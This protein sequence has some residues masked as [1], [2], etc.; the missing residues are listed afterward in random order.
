MIWAVKT[1]KQKKYER[2]YGL[3]ID[4]S[5]LEG[6]EP[7]YIVLFNH[8]GDDD[9]VIVGM[10]L[11]PHLANFMVSRWVSHKFPTGPLSTLA[12]AIHKSRFIPDTD[13]VLCAK[14]VLRN[15]KGIVAIAPAA[16]FSID[17]TTHYFDY[18]IAKLVRLFKVP[19]FAVKMSGLFLFHNGYREQ[20]QG[21][22]LKS[23]VIP[24]F[25]GDEL[26]DMS[27]EDIYKR[28]FEACDFND[29][30]Y[31][32][33]QQALITAKNHDLAE[34]MEYLTYRCLRCGK[35]FTMRSRG[36]RLYCTACGNT[37]K[38]NDRY[39]LEPAESGSVCARSFDAWNAIQRSHLLQEIRDDDFCITA[40]CRLSHYTI[41]KAF[42]FSEYGRGTLRLDHT[43]FT[44]TGTDMGG[45]VV[46]RYP[47]ISTP[48]I[49]NFI[50]YYLSFDSMDNVCRYQLDDMHMAVKYMQALL[51]LRLV[52]FPHF[53]GELD[54]RMSLPSM[55]I[56]Q[57]L[58]VSPS[59]ASE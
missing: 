18:G 55:Q 45:E 28:L 56:D 13:S 49:G 15:R 6:V 7:P 5:A 22:R 30:Q 21:C 2:A 12:G 36:D 35:E 59:P 37:V 14:R 51:L 43:G 10:T 40:P 32:S 16:S 33:Q 20:R 44:Y 47:L 48:Y 17:G 25:R 27:V 19:V 57:T 46:Y 9:H 58:C 3:T 52:H 50:P 8:V 23:E 54:W 1:F 34:G 11:Y 4:R 41:G 24:I 38:L 39:F 31:Q 42:G 53:D 26:G 29:F